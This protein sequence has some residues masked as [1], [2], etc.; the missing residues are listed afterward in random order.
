MEQESQIQND[1][2]KLMEE[3]L[4]KM[5]KMNPPKIRHKYIFAMLQDKGSPPYHLQAAAICMLQ[6]H[7]TLYAGDY[8]K[9]LEG[10]WF[11]YKRLR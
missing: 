6:K 5:G 4:E 7:G 1:N 11:F 3:E 10:T 9:E 8:L 2:K